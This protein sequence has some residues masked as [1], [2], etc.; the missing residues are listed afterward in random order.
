MWLPCECWGDDSTSE[1]KIIP[2]S[3][4]SSWACQENNHRSWPR[5]LSLCTSS[6]EETEPLFPLLFFLLLPSRDQILICDIHRASTIVT[7]HQGCTH[8]VIRKQRLHKRVTQCRAFT[9]GTRSFAVQKHSR[10]LPP[11]GICFIICYPDQSHLIRCGSSGH[12]HA[13]QHRSIDTL[14]SALRS[15]SSMSC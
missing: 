5:W 15:F 10:H 6:F 2:C 8:T 12:P 13:Y 1:H 4:L 3:N 14:L 7:K 9:R 11:I